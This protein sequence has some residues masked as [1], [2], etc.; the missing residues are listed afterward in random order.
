MKN[1]TK[2]IAMGAFG[3]CLMIAS[4]LANAQPNDPSNQKIPSLELDQAD[5]RDALRQLF[6]N[7]GDVSYTLAPDVV[8]V[9]TVRLKDVSFE[10]ALRNVLQQVDATYRI[11]GGVYQI[12]RKEQP[13]VTGGNDN[14]E[15]PTT[16]T[17]NKVTARIKIRHADPQYII[18]MLNGSLG[19]GTPPEISG[20]SGMFGGGFGGG[21]GGGFG[22]GMGGFGG[23]QGGFGGGGFGGSGGFGGGGFGGSGGFG[24]GRGGG[25]GGG[26]FGGGSG[27]FGGGGFGGRGF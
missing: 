1:L 21:M 5:I 19:P 11:E 22:G 7:V 25:F 12:I 2:F 8:G 6:K 23:G 4:P 14:T 13:I 27:G 3:L 24:G 18:G 17:D 26:G 16:P 15:L 20:L 10:T 9:V